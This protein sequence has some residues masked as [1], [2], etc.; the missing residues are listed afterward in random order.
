M[1]ELH[2]FRRE[3]RS[4]LESQKFNIF[5]CDREST[6]SDS[7]STIVWNEDEDHED[8]FRIARD[9]G[10]TIIFEHI[11]ELTEEEL[12]DLFDKLPNNLKQDIEPELE[13]TRQKIQGSDNITGISFFWIKD[14]VKYTIQR[15]SWLDDVIFVCN[16]LE[17]FAEN[18][19]KTNTNVRNLLQLDDDDDNDNDSD[20]D[21]DNDS[22]IDSDTD[23][24]Y[25]DLL[26]QDPNDLAREM[27]EYILDIDPNVDGRRRNKLEKD[28]WEIKGLNPKEY[29]EFKQRISIVASRLMAREQNAHTFN[30]GDASLPELTKR[31]VEW[32]QKNDITKPT[33]AI[34]RG[35]LLDNDI[36]LNPETLRLL[37]RKIKSE[38]K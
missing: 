15:R 5:V 6:F 3:I 7:L 17:K 20:N 12:E 16:G 36:V 30:A 33:Q 28:F 22:D 24:I 14:N 4:Y 21:D 32:V 18:L 9:E 25:E 38:L 2:E 19:K 37:C 34:I 13:E 8:F 26:D 1:S 27:N 31:C 11:E 29:S 10:I 35:Y 23:D